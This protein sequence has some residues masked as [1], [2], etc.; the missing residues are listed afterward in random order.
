[1]NRPKFLPYSLGF[2]ALSAGIVW[3]G[4][5]TL[6]TYYPSPTGNYNTL[7]AQN[8]SIGT[9][10]TTTA[11]LL[12][13][14]S[15]TGYVAFNDGGCGSNYAGIG[16][17]GQIPTSC[18]NY[19]ILSSPTD[20][21]L[22]LNRPTGHGMRFRMNN[23]DQMIIDSN[24][25]VGIGV[26]N[27]SAP[28]NIVGSVQNMVKINSSAIDT[29]LL[30]TN[31]TAGGHDW[32]IISSGTGSW[33]S[34]GSFAIQDFT[35]NANRLLIDQSGNVGIGVSAPTTARL[36]IN[37]PSGS[38]GIDLSTA[39]SYADM[40]VI[41][42]TLSGLDN[43]LYLGYGQASGGNIYMYG[44]GTT[45]QMTLTGDGNVTIVGN[46]QVNGN[47]SAGGTI[48]CCGTSDKRLKQN[49][50]PLTGTLSKLDQLRGV[51][52]EWNHLAASMGHKEGEK[53]I[54]MIAQELQKVYPQ[55]VTAS[56][57][58]P[59]YLSIDYDKF[60]AVLLQSVK[61][62]KSQTNAMQDQIN[63]L[64]RKVKILEKHK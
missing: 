44:Q 33:D 13:T 15:G 52:F 29:M 42:N 11:K 3:A 61:E 17:N 30:L 7:T 19:N 32:H 36:V 49:I 21:E 50:I 5:I 14:G 56:K 58:G 12:V 63:A 16:L 53:S 34:A 45:P 1:M 54:G 35:A 38:T 2:L 24:G 20:Q 46:L 41:R 60:T 8:V 22:Y 25:N 51:S 37:T 57:N 39:D 48:S 4:Q 62:L 27:P 31:T 18:V 9:T 26:T 55:L 43:N 59:K 10:T 6:T 23:N 64:Q 40:R 28:L 47:I